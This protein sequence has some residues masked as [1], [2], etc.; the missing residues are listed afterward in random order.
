MDEQDKK[1]EDRNEALAK[2]LTE[3]LE[4]HLPAIQENIQKFGRWLEQIKFDFSPILK[5]VQID[6]AA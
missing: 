6:W 5:A 3:Y 1:I 2:K 4:P